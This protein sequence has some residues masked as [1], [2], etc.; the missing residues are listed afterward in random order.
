MAANSSRA[1]PKQIVKYAWFG[2]IVGFW[3]WMNFLLWKTEFAGNASWAGSGSP[4]RVLAKVLQSSDSSHLEISQGGKRL[5]H[6]RWSAT[7]ISETAPVVN[8]SDEPLE[9]SVGTIEAY[10]IDFDGNI[11]V[12]GLGGLIR[13]NSHL[14]FDTNLTWE[15]FHV[16]FNL[17]PDFYEVRLSRLEQEISFRATSAEETILE[18]KFSMAQLSNPAFL[19][20]ELGA[21]APLL[22]A[23]PLMKSFP[24]P[25][26][27]QTNAG[28]APASPGS[29]SQTLQLKW[30]ARDTF[31]QF[32]NSR[33][34]VH[35]VETMLLEK[36]PVR[37]WISKAGEVLRAELPNQIL[38]KNES[39]SNFKPVKE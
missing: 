18:R 10:T 17:K 5:G 2:L 20:Q 29:T 4:A 15:T 32:G 33:I 13:F 6:G 36:H 12:P 22:L 27:G 34:R 39:F 24:F 28:N 38:V 8:D 3:L 14:R 25:A 26:P 21:A 30:K 1:N 7:L 37:L 16:G 11:S 23:M 9:G 19:S 31:L 35:Q